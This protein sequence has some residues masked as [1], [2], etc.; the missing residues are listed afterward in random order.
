MHMECLGYAVGEF[1]R[2]QGLQEHKATGIV[3]QSKLV[4]GSQT[5]ARRKQ[6]LGLLSFLQP[7]TL[8]QRN[9]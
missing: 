8:L 9:V 2:K 3:M 6:T 5:L 4:S 1:K 7:V